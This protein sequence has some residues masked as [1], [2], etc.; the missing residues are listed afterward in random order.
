[1]LDY[2]A[3]SEDRFY[4]PKAGDEVISLTSQQINWLMDGYD[5]NLL[6]RHKQRQYKRIGTI[7]AGLTAQWQ[8]R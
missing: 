6:R 4:W 1:V 2:K 5:I 8:Y 7:N 3:L